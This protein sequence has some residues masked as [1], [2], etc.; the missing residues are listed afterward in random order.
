MRRTRAASAFDASVPVRN[1]RFRFL[2][3]LVR[4]CDL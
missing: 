3:F 1:L 4:M 2:F